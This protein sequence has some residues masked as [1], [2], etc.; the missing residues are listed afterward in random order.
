MKNIKTRRKK[1]KNKKNGTEFVEFLKRFPNLYFILF[2]LWMDFFPMK[3]N[4][5]TK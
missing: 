4:F 3:D 5:K 2:L 1:L